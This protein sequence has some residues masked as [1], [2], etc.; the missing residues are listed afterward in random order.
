MSLQRTAG[1]LQ[2]R[3]P[4]NISH[5]RAHHHQH[6]EPQQNKMKWHWFWCKF[7]VTK[8]VLKHSRR[9]RLSQTTVVALTAVTVSWTEE[10][11]AIFSV[12]DS[13]PC[14]ARK[15]YFNMMNAQ[16]QDLW[17]SAG[18]ECRAPVFPPSRSTQMR[19]R[20]GVGGICCSVMNKWCQGTHG[21]DDVW[22]WVVVWQGV[23]SVSFFCLWIVF[24]VIY[25]S[26]VNEMNARCFV[27]DSM[28]TDWICGAWHGLCFNARHF[29][30]TGPAC[31]KGLTTA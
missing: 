26:F 27:S 17:M 28:G 1:R 31:H 4:G 3:F 11:V 23:K 15:F 30:T 21:N 22:L 7:R 18:N 29:T 10:L 19:T 14:H 12:R 9:S 8:L 6:A 13:A 5:S 20:D 25:E 16:R 2:R 24:G